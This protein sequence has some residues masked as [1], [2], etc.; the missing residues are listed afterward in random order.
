[1]VVI[2]RVPDHPS[3]TVRARWQFLPFS[4]CNAVP[5]G[6][7]SRRRLVIANR[8]LFVFHASLALAVCVADTEWNLRVPLY[9]TSL[10]W[11]ISS[12]LLQPSYVESGGLYLTQ[13][14]CAFFLLSAFFHL[15]AGFLWSKIYLTCIEHAACPF[16]WIEYFFSASIMFAVIAYPC[17]VLGFELLLACLALVATT[18]LFGLLTEWVAR[19][20]DADNWNH[21]VL[22]RLTP[23]LLGYFPQVSAWALLLIIFGYNTSSGDRAPPDFV[24]AIVASE[25]VFFFSFGA[26]QFVQV[27]RPPS[28]YVR[29][30]Y[31]YQALS[32]LSKG[33]LGIVLITQVLFYSNYSCVLDNS[34]TECI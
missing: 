31:W 9:R 26:V 4:H 10:E 21:P 1:M 19:P 34:G 27:L 11:N 18:M 20:V 33:V 30:E 22:T 28:W 23:H 25:L 17:G 29:G 12:G 16:R 24:Y 7:K 13:L 32:L 6:P 15:G 2:G 5:L 8:L 3:P 14:T